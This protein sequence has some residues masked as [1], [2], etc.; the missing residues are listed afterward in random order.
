MRTFRDI[1]IVALLI[2]SP[3]LVE[4][5]TAILKLVPFLYESVIVLCIAGFVW[6]FNRVLKEVLK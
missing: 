4:L 5:L 1:L 2:L 6:F 3:A